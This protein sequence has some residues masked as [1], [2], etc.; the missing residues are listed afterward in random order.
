MISRDNL[1]TARGLENYLNMAIATSEPLR[2]S[3]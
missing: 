1:S 3:R 2:G